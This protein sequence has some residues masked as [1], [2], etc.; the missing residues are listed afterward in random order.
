MPRKDNSVKRILVV[1][2]D[3]AACAYFE[4]LLAGDGIEVVSEKGGEQGLKRLRSESPNPVH[5]LVLDLMMPGFS[6]YEVLRRLQNPEYQRDVPTFVV[7]AR[8]LDAGTVEM[9][10]GESNV[11]EFWNKPID[12]VRFKKRVEEVLRDPGGTRAR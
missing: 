11:W 6:G 9:I 2:D 7:T 1:D 5:L 8:A 4:S 12:S 3:P 10:R